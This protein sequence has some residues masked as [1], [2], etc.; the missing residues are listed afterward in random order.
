MHLDSK[1]NH[2]S[3]CM[4]WDY[5]VAFFVFASWLG[6]HPCTPMQHPI[7]RHQGLLSHQPSVLGL[8]QLSGEL[9]GTLGPLK[10]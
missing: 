8:V 1:G 7:S 9:E 2:G 5:Q 6:E 3:P 10:N 4:P